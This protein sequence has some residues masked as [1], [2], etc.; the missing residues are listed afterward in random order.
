MFGTKF[1]ACFSTSL[2]EKPQPEASPSIMK[3]R[4]VIPLL[5]SLLFIRASQRV[6]LSPPEEHI[7]HLAAVDGIPFCAIAKSTEMR[8]RLRARGMKIPAKEQDVHSMVM[9]YATELQEKVK[10]NLTHDIFYGTRFSL[11]LDEWTSLRNRQYMS[12]TLRKPGQHI[13]LG[14]I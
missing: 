5:L 12:L 10:S 13:G 9:S 4:Q 11:I 8:A 2:A 6:Q 1:Q 7:S 14:M 3:C